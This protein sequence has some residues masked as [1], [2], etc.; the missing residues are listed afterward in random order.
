ME[1]TWF[2]KFA[3]DPM[4]GERIIRASL[5]SFGNADDEGDIIMTGAADT[6]LKQNKTLV[7]HWQHITRDVIGEWR[8]M[9]VEGNELKADG[10]LCEGVKKAD[11]AAI[12]VRDKVVKGTS[13]RFRPRTR[14]SVKYYEPENCDRYMACEYTDIII[15]EGSLVTQPANKMAKIHSYKSDDGQYDLREIERTLIDA[16]MTRKDASHFI[17]HYRKEMPATPP[18]NEE[19]APQKSLY[20][21]LLGMLKEAA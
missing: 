20:G 11:E 9:R 16:G 10:Y 2:F 5:T 21:E 8:N 1:R 7:M 6:F 12:L 4:D 19:P 13:I 17:S 3:G 18:A 14:S 15:R